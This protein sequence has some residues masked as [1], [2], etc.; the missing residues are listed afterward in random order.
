LPTTLVTIAIAM[1]P[2][3]SLLLATLI[4]VTIALIVTHHSHHRHHCPC[5]H[6]PTTLVTIAITLATIAFAI[7][8]ACC[9]GCH[10]NHPLCCLSL[11]LPA[12]LVTIRPLL[13]REGEDHT[14]PMS[15]PTMTAANGATIII[16]TF[17]TCTTGREGPVQQRA[18]F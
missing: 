1:P 8:I 13:G 16:A 10:C 17:A 9:P 15:N 7:I 6:S 2:S 11:H 5:C 12:T 4:A 3:P 18:G 14:N